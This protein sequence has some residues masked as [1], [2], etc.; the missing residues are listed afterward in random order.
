MPKSVK[1]NGRTVGPGAPVY[2]VAEMSANHGGDYAAAVKI[3][4]EAKA[5][6]ADAVKL[7]TYTADTLTIQSDQ[8]W[9]RVGRGSPWEGRKLYDLYKE[10]YTPWEW[11][12]KL[13]KVAERLGLDLFSSPF[14]ATAVDFLKTMDVPCYKI[15]SFEIVDIPLIRRVAQTGKPMILS[16][17]MATRAEVA[18]A[19]REARAYGARNIVLLKCTSAYPAPPEEMN[20]RA[21]PA[22]ARAFDVPVGLS[23]HTLGSAVAVASVALGACLIEKHF[24][25]SRKRGG[26]DSS[27]SM[28]PAEFKAMA[29]AVRDTEKALGR[30]AY[31]LGQKEKESRAFRR[32]LF[33]VQDMEKGDLFTEANLRSIRP[34]NG[35]PPK[36]YSDV[37]GKR[38]AR[39]IRRGTPLSWDLV[40]Q[41]PDQKRRRLKKAP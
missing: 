29:R 27:F 32:S 18:D 38:A 14:D 10:A 3:L 1:I 40:E 16:T 31:L 33:V 26:P 35:L 39:A 12:P 19:L 6:G 37:L 2:L 4:E 21:I 34:A 7:Q 22:L 41:R 13:K 11:H 30:S 28:E 8:R 23:D 5:A 9:F 25:L 36:W 24:T 15:A 20:L 17:G